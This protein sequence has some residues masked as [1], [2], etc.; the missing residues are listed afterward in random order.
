LRLPDVAPV[1][2]GCNYLVHN[3]PHIKFQHNWAL[4]SYFIDDGKFSLKEIFK[5]LL[6]IYQCFGQICIAH[7]QKMLF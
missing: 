5:Q 7:E 3:A 4:H 1:I 2:L 6:S